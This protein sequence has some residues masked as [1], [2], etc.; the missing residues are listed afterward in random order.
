[1]K[2][3]EGW[4]N[5]SGLGDAPRSVLDELAKIKSG[6]VV[7]PTQNSKGE[8]LPEIRLRRVTEP[9]PAQKLLLNRPGLELPRRLRQSIG[10]VEM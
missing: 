10:S 9:E 2:T 7:L 6:D 5:R 4:M 8:S 3:L 1:W